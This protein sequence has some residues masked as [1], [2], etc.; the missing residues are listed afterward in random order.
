MKSLKFI[1]HDGR[2][3]EGEI[4]QNAINS[5]CNDM[6]E[7]AHKCFKEDTYASHVT[8]E[9]KEKLRDDAIAQAERIRN[10]E[11]KLTS[12]WLWQ[13]INEKLTG[14]CIAFLPK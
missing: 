2:L 3:F 7:S 8:L 14:E 11:E 9:R 1:A 13:R 12:F 6:I 10:G 4:L 5:V